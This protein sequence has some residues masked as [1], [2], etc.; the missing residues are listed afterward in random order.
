MK[1]QIEPEKQAT[2]KCEFTPQEISY[3]KNMARYYV[4]NPGNDSEESRAA[5]DRLVK[6]LPISARI[7]DASELF[8]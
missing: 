8:K 4:A 1:V 7:T 3:I 2:V 6:K 5:A